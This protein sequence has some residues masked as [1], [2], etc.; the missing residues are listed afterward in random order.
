MPN[1]PQPDARVTPPRAIEGGRVVVEAGLVPFPVDP[2]P[3]LRVGDVAARLTS[4]SS[5]RLVFVVPGGV[6]GRAPITLGDATGD[7]R[8]RRGGPARR[9]RAA[10]GG[11]PRV[12][13]GGEPVRHRV[14]DARPARAGVHLQGDAGRRPGAARVGHRQRHL[15][16]LRPVRRSLRE[17]PVRGDGLPRQG[18]RHGREVRVGPGRRVRAGIHAGRHDVRRRPERHAVPRERRGTGR[19]V[20]RRCR[21]ASRPSTWRSP[22]TRRS[23]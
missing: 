16:G 13:C 18:G 6:E 1:S 5:R 20:R 19:P 4:A 7:D 22:R 15:A 9:D 8:R 21:R 3:D 2:L 10:P 11:R 12:R 14:G 17:Q 23:T